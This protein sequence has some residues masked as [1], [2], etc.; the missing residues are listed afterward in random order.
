M[1]VMT[2]IYIKILIF[3]LYKLLIIIFNIF[4]IKCFVQ[5]FFLKIKFKVLNLSVL[6]FYSD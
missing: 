2:F 3:Y 5:W 6:F 1:D 4:K